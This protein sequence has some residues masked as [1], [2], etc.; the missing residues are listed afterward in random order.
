MV[1]NSER[2]N[3]VSSDDTQTIA[4]INHVTNGLHNLT[5]DLYEDLMERDHEKAKVK[6]TNICKLM[7]ELI[8]SLTNEI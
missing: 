4:H 2:T 7:S 6:A 5:N 8:H 3:R 1:D